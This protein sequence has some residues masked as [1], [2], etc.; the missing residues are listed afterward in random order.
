MMTWWDAYDQHPPMVPV[1]H[2]GSHWCCLEYP[3]ELLW[4]RVLDGK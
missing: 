2:P 3:E 4:F 1:H